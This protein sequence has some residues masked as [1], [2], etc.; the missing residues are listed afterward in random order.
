MS[1]AR[2]VL[3]GAFQ[4]LDLSKPGWMAELV[5]RQLAALS[6]H[7]LRIAPD[8][9]L[10]GTAPRIHGQEILLGRFRGDGWDL[11]MSDHW[12][13]NG[14]HP[15]GWCDWSGDPPTHWAPWFEPL[16]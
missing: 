6:A 13:D 4:E 2:K 8:W 16:R 11:V 9:Q 3:L 10:I 5:D 14:D 1:E 7:A 12:S 15:P